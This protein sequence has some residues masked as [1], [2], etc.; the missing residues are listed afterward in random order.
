MVSS[1]A[2]RWPHGGKYCVAGG[3][4][5]VS[6]TNNQHMVGVSINRF[7]YATKEPERHAKWVK[8]IQKHQPAWK[9]S[10]TSVIC[11]SHFEDSCFKQNRKVAASL[12]MN[13]RLKPDAYEAPYASKFQAIT[14]S[15]Q[16]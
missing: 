11:R 12:G 9:P 2:K 13:A 8:F 6:R 4:K 1:G 7:P 16:S 3:P 10:N 5:N 15:R 14:Q